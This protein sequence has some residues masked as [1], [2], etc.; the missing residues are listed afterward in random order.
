V[1]PLEGIEGLSLQAADAWLS[2]FDASND[3]NWLNAAGIVDEGPDPS[4]MTSV[5]TEPRTS[6]GTLFRACQCPEHQEIYNNWPTQDADL[7]IAKCMKNC[8]Y[9]G[10]YF[11]FAAELR[12]HIGRKYGGRN[13]T[14]VYEP[15]KSLHSL[16][17]R[18][19]AKG[20]TEGTRTI[21][22]TDSIDAAPS[23]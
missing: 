11:T 10:K 13:L 18:W 9:C 22:P 21:R 4:P 20:N 19:T 5:A 6:Q 16:I 2:E 7:V 12:R 1:Y 17:P 23:L 3:G 8:M 14:V 15:R